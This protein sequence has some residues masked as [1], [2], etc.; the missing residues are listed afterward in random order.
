MSEYNPYPTE[1]TTSAE[2]KKIARDREYELA[3]GRR[4]ESI[5]TTR[6]GTVFRNYHTT[7]LDARQEIA[8][9]LQMADDAK[10]EIFDSLVG[11]TVWPSAVDKAERTRFPFGVTASHVAPPR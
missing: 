6:R 7:L 11:L 3:H 4:Y 10:T 8:D 2:Q 1:V 9:K 5:V